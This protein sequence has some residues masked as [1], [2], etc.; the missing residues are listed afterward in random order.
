MILGRVISF[1][2]YFFNYYFLNNF[3]DDLTNSFHYIQDII[4]GY[5]QIL[6]ISLAM[7]ILCLL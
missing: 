5:Y 7:F 3:S 1:N 6:A 4:K 2:K